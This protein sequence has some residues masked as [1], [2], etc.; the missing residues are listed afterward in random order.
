MKKVIYFVLPILFL[1]LV[2]CQKEEYEVITEQ[3]QSSITTDMEVYDLVYRAAMHDGSA[4]DG[5]DNSHCFSIEFPYIVNHQGEM[6]EITSEAVLRDFL[7]DLP[8]NAPDIIPNFPVTVINAGH[9][10]VTVRNR[11]QLAGLQQACR[12]MSNERGGPITC[13]KF[14]FPLRITSYERDSQQTGSTNLHSREELFLYFD[15]LGPGSVVNF[16]YPLDVVKNNNP[17]SVANRN[18][19]ENL[20]RDCGE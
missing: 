14:S 10:R 6:I 16:V 8:T 20:L 19:L 3:D 18:Q 1:F 17:V 2:S 4:D 12:N 9:Q 11:Q 13:L 5:L 15:N 7:A